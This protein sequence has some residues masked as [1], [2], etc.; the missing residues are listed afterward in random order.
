[1]LILEEQ[2]VLPFYIENATGVFMRKSLLCI[3]VLLAFA[4]SAQAQTATEALRTTWLSACSSGPIKP[5]LAARCNEIFGAG[6][7]PIASRELQSAQGNNLETLSS[8]GRMMM[9]MVK[10][11]GKQALAIAKNQNDS[12]W[13]S[14]LYLNNATEDSGILASGQ[15]WSMIGSTGFSQL[16]RADSD[17]ERGYGQD[18]HY[19]LLGASYRFNDKLSG[20]LA[21]QIEKSNADFNRNTGGLEN[22][23]KTVSLAM[24]YWPTANFGL[25]F[26]ASH[27]QLE[28]TLTRRI[29]YNFDGVS[30]D[31]TAD[32]DSSGSMQAYSLD[33][34]WETA[35]GAWTWRYGAGY[36]LQNSTIDAIFENNPR[37][38]DFG[39]AEQNIESRQW[40][41]NVQLAK[42]IS[43]NAGVWQPFA[44]LRWVHESADDPRLIR[45]RFRAGGD[46]FRLR[47]ATAEPD[48]SF[49]QLSVGINAALIRG[50]QG[51]ARYQILLAHEFMNENQFEFGF[52]KE[53]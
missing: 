19:L 38:L 16:D 29:R 42:T 33:A 2:T 50:W 36:S 12:Q 35:A 49:G 27:G 43:S 25:N 5:E 18:S 34:G 3:A 48:R 28:S 31:T 40:S 47:F 52:S 51:Y 10:M 39:I 8:M 13:Q 26:S 46:I 9:A 14:N 41:G 44:S 37:G 23:N 30:V 17:F 21:Y 45:A 7:T 24:D 53:F 6:S 20:V 4:P 32:S 15:N 1:M 22:E 11:R